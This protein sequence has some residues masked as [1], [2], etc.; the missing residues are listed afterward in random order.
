MQTGK[1]QVKSRDFLPREIIPVRIEDR[2]NRR[3]RLGVYTASLP[4]RLADAITPGRHLN[5]VE[6]RRTGRRR[7]GVD[8]YRCGLIKDSSQQND[9]TLFN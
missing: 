3:P 1:R 7:G 4:S 6:H 8:A 5:F 2:S 9:S